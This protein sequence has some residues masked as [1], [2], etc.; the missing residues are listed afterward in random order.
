MSLTW[1]AFG[2]HNLDS[3]Q[4]IKWV[5]TDVANLS[6]QRLFKTIVDRLA[7]S[8]STPDDKIY[9]V[10]NGSLI[11]NILGGKL[12]LMRQFDDTNIEIEFNEGRWQ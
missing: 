5:P 7:S 11:F 8:Y 1:L 10:R 9:Q 6:R 2:S 12:R 4:L 3:L